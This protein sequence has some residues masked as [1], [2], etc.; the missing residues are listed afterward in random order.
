MYFITILRNDWTLLTKSQYDTEIKL[1]LLF[2]YG[3]LVNILK[4]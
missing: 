2:I 3:S 1:I 4:E